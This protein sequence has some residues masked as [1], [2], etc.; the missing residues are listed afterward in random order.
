MLKR[1]RAELKYSV[2][3]NKRGFL[4]LLRKRIFFEVKW[5][6]KLSGFYGKNNV[7]LAEDIKALL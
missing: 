6:T 2:L 4:F 1:E 7:L 3:E 5:R